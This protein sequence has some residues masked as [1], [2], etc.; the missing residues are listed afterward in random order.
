MKQSDNKQP[1]AYDI[2]WDTVSKNL[3]DYGFSPAAIRKTE[4]AK[5]FL[6]EHPIPKEL[7]DLMEAQSDKK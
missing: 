4:K 6:E 3:K 2:D 1:P 7:L 5:K